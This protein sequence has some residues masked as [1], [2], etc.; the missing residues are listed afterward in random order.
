MVGYRDRIMKR[1][2]KT[3]RHKDRVGESVRDIESEKEI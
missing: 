3:K 1:D 2:T